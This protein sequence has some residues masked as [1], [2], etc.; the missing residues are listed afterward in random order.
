MADDFLDTFSDAGMFDA[1]PSSYTDSSGNAPTP[2]NFGNLG[3]GLSFGGDLLSGFGA[4]QIGNEEAGAYEYNASLAQDQEKIDLD[5]LDRE[6]TI[7]ASE[8]RAGYL[9]SGV[10]LSG[11]P[12][13]TMV[14]SASQVALDKQIIEYNTKSKVDMLNY[15]GQVA[16]NQGKFKMGQSILSG[17]IGLISLL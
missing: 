2:F 5:Q 7:L 14:Q 17:G 1:V 16:K 10:T 9:K 8:Q 6:G 4:L 11:S 3:K 13:D 15:E 12:L